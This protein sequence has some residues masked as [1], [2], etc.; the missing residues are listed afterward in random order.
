MFEVSFK[1][2]GMLIYK[3]LVQKQE[4]HATDLKT[5]KAIALQVGLRSFLNTG[6]LVQTKLEIT[7]K[8]K[9]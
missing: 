5:Q 3:M 1:T 4:T 2:K 7:V 9:Q 8:Q 6:W